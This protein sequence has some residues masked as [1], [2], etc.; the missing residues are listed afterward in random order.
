MNKNKDI[1]EILDSIY[2]LI[3]EAKKVKKIS[4]ENH[5]K[6][7]N[8]FVSKIFRENSN[9]KKN[10][11]KISSTTSEILENKGTKSKVLRDWKHV[12]FKLSQ[13]KKSKSILSEKTETLIGKIFLEEFQKWIIKKDRLIKKISLDSTNKLLKKKIIDT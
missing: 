5:K 11:I 6:I 2:V 9:S 10:N 12:N 4:Y 8:G 3:N 13:Q 7:T 1:V